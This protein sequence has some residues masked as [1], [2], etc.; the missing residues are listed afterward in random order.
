LARISRKDKLIDVNLEMHPIMNDAPMTSSE[1]EILKKK[2]TG[3]TVTIDAQR[4]ELTRMA[5]L[6]G[7]VIAINCNGGALVQFEGSDP[8][9]YEIGPEYLEIEESS[10]V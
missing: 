6:H 2:Y 10:P 9:W 1:F 4:P 8:G 7:R 3:K 5:G